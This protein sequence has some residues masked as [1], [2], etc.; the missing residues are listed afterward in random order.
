MKVPNSGR[1]LHLP[2]CRKSRRFLR[3][4]YRIC[5]QECLVLGRKCH[6]L[7]GLGGSLGVGTSACSIQKDCGRH[8]SRRST[9]SLRAEKR[10]QS[11]QAREIQTRKNRGGD[12]R[13][14]WILSASITKALHAIER[15][16]HHPVTRVFGLDVGG[17]CHGDVGG[18][19]RGLVHSGTRSIGGVVRG[20][21][22]KISNYLLS[23][24]LVERGNLRHC[25]RKVLREWP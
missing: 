2:S 6:R 11:S 1:D 18:R 7:L 4:R 14:L 25:E 3:S 10:T 9:G 8:D 21:L 20:G 5:I 16:Y 23:T 15:A 13:N 17:R 24:E 12:V 22:F 19:F